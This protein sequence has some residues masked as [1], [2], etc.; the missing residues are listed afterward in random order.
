MPIVIYLTEVN[1]GCKEV[2]YHAVKPNYTI[3]YFTLVLP[4]NKGKY[5]YTFTQVC[6]Q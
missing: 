6:T 4:A 3:T 1:A 2:W 5:N